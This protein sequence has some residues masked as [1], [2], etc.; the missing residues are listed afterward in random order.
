MQ[1]IRASLLDSGASN[2]RRRLKLDCLVKFSSQK[3]FLITIHVIFFHEQVLNA[4]W[5]AGIP[6][7]SEN[8]LPC[9]D[10]QGFN[11][12]LENAKP[13]T[14]PD[15][16]CLAAFTYLRLNPTLMEEKNFKEFG[17]FVKR[18]HGEWSHGFK[19]SGR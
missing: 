12:I 16:R 17:R 5:D 10:R 13:R 15:G 19:I 8:A 11:K 14:D 4:A 6:V 18:L 1:L 2:F 7:A 9:Y 3:G